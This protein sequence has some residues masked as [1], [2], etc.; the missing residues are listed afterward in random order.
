MSVSA[1]DKRNNQ[2]FRTYGF[3]LDSASPEALAWMEQ[4]WSDLKMKE[5]QRTYHREGERAE[6][7]ISAYDDIFKSHPSIQYGW[8]TEDWEFTA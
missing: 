2:R 7:T 5:I 1:D 6:T 4:M 3:P 8:F